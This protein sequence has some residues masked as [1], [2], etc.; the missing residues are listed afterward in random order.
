MVGKFCINHRLSP[1]RGLTQM[2]IA[3][4]LWQYDPGCSTLSDPNFDFVMDQ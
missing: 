1:V 3:N 2:T 4:D